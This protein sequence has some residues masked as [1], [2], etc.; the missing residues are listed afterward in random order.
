MRLMK[1][2]VRIHFTEKSRF[3]GDMEKVMPMYG[4]ASIADIPEILENSLGFKKNFHGSL[5][6]GKDFPECDHLIFVL[7]DGFGFHTL[8]WALE[9]NHLKNTGKFLE[10]S[11]LDIISSTFPSTTSTA[12]IS[13]HT[14]LTP[15]DHG[16]LGYIQYLASVGS[17]CN[18]ISLSPLGKSGQ[19]ILSG[20]LEIGKILRR[21]TVHSVLTENG[22]S[23]YYYSPSSIINSELT[24]LT[25]DSAIKRG[26]LSHSHLFTMIRSD[27]QKE[28][29][30]SL[31]FCYL[32]T[33]D[34]ISH[35]VGPYTNETANE[36]ESIF[37]FIRDLSDI[38]HLKR[39]SGIVISADHGH[40]VVPPC[41]LI[42]LALDE[43]IRNNM[44]SPVVGDVRSPF[45][46]LRH[47]F[48][49]S[50]MVEISELHRNVESMEMNNATLKGLFGNRELKPL[51]F[52]SGEDLV[53]FPAHGTG[54]TDSTLAMLDPDYSVKEMI[55]MH[56]GLSMEEMEIPL[57]NYFGNR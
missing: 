38:C 34:T 16:I 3:N 39:N 41:G 44:I 12:T 13:C 10:E 49:E 15:G 29:G 42:D 6:A 20:G 28:K 56:G 36:I 31:H 35:K 25:A 51:N 40:T 7:L 30:R 1:P 45:V 5:K 24:K 11:F 48:L 18:M 17:V 23:S 54:V 9:N 4:S 22:I 27:I 26:Y 57:I 14:G 8:K 53:L 32:S 2:E 50:V 52:G 43:K 21:G 33:V 46:H 19:S 47:G 37:R 55:G